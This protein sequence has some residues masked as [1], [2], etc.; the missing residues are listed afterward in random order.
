MPIGAAIGAIG[1]I[2]GGIL[3]NRSQKR[4]IE[5]Q[6]KAQK[7]YAQNAIQWR[8]TDAKKAGIHPLAAIGGAGAAS[9]TPMSAGGNPLGAGIAEGASQIGNAISGRMDR[10]VA[11]S[12]LDVNTAQADLL[13]AQTAQVLA[14]VRAA[15]QGSTTGATNVSAPY[16]GPYKGA[17]E[18]VSLGEPAKP[19]ILNESPSAYYR[20]DAVPRSNPDSPEQP[21]ETMWTW[22]RR[23]DFF[24]NLGELISRNVNWNN[25]EQGARVYNFIRDRANAGDP[26]AKRALEMIEAARRKGN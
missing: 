8:A 18:P 1:S 9:Y 3:G 6:M 26:K 5:A 2:A 4:M 22:F 20:G 23:G 12:A 19:S 14:G 16:D 10:K 11:A 24:K 21:E 13:R 7:E 25:R 17:L 15:T